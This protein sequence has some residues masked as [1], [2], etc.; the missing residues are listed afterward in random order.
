MQGKEET[1]KLIGRVMDALVILPWAGN[2]KG[3]ESEGPIYELARYTTNDWLTDVHE[4][5]MLDL[6]RKKVRQTP[7]GFKIEIENTYFYGFLQK[8]YKTCQT[9]EY[10]EDKYFIHAHEIGHALSSGLRRQVA[11]LVNINDNHWVAVIL[12]FVHDLI[13]L[14]D[15][16][17]QNKHVM[18]DILEWWTKHHSGRQFTVQPLAI[19]CQQDIFSCGLLSFNALAHHFL[20][21]LY[22]LVDAMLVANGRLEMMLEVIEQHLDQVHTPLLL[23]D[24]LI[25]NKPRVLNQS[26]KTS[27]LHSRRKPLT[28]QRTTPKL[29]MPHPSLTQVIVR[30][31]HLMPLMTTQEIS[32]LI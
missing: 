29:P 23:S 17:D 4:S 8:A 22:P 20:P 25:I 30:M 12:D 24:L 2:I 6:L 1:Y 19:T 26:A 11:F 18:K 9:K 7:G 16:L 21:G 10:E 5:Q 31:T 32:N 3:F 15:S 13:L 14:G 28:P 27:N